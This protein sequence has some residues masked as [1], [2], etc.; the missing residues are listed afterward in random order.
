[1][2]FFRKPK[3]AKDT[4]RI[5]RAA[6]EGL[7]SQAKWDELERLVNSDAEPSETSGATADYAEDYSDESLG[8]SRRGLDLKAED[9]RD[10]K[11][12][13]FASDLRVDLPDD[14]EFEDVTSPSPQS[15]PQP[16]IDAMMPSE[17]FE[18]D[19]MSDPL[20]EPGASAQS[21]AQDED[22][23]PPHP[24]AD[25]PD[26]ADIGTMR[27]DVAR[28]SADIQSGEE[29]YRRAQQRIENLTNFVERA[30]V[31]FSML[32]RLEPENRRLKAR[33]R[34]IQREIDSNI[35]KM[36]VLRADLEDR[37]LKLAEKTRVY[38]STLGKLS[39]AQKSLQEYER[40]LHNTRGSSDRNALKSERLQTSLDVERRENEVLRSRVTEIATEMEAKKTAYI[41]AKKVADS[42]AQDCSDFRQQAETAEKDADALRKSLTT[43]QTQNNAMKAEMI[44]LHEDIRAFKTQSEFSIISREDEMTALQQQVSLL[45][46]QLEIKDEILQNAARDVQDLRKVRTAQDLERERLESQIETQAYQL[47]QANSELLKSKQDVTDFDRRYRDVA[48]ALSVAQARRTPTQTVE[49]P[50]IQPLPPK[51]TAKAPAKTK[52]KKQAPKAKAKQPKSDDELSELSS[53]DVNERIVDFRLGLRNDLT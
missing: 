8:S 22:Y 46:K 24:G 52:A 7:S 4:G 19:T 42:L 35:Q 38:E 30:E 11:P 48:T 49:T 41:E 3:K 12:S 6:G 16:S 34:T 23:L 9:L 37:E 15:R 13:T 20:T 21:K 29:L 39:V 51:T 26:R 5:G 43:A 53:E 31:D 44:S 33:N 40:A 1:M 32:N 18:R 17:H 2:A 36:D 27:L 50:D 25:R 14:I 28:I 10:A 45:T 47:D